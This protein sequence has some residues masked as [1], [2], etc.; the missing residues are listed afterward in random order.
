MLHGDRL[1]VYGLR[2]DYVPLVKEGAEARSNGST[3]LRVVQWLMWA[4]RCCLWIPMLV[5]SIHEN[6]I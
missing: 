6:G 4:I 5:S 3:G 2:Q 1:S